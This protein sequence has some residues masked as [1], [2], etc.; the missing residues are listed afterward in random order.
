[1]KPVVCGEHKKREQQIASARWRKK[2]AK[3][4]K[5]PHS[6][7]WSV[8]HL[9]S[10]PESI[11]TNNGWEYLSTFHLTNWWTNFHSMCFSYPSMSVVKNK[12]KFSVYL[13]CISNENRMQVFWTPLCIYISHTQSLKDVKTFYGSGKSKQLWHWLLA[14]HNE[15]NIRCCWCIK[16]YLLDN[17]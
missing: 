1:M 10:L 6:W 14:K 4:T 17:F 5:L 11:N 7:V 2:W 3:S 15:E 16:Q 8:C 13:S 9:S 12:G